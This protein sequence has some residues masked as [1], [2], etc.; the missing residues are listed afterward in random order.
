MA[1]ENKQDDIF[2][3]GDLPDELADRGREVW[4]AGLGAV[5]TVEE[6]GTK[7]F[8]T[9]VRRGEQFEQRGKKQLDAAASEINHQQK[10]A[11]QQVEG[12]VGRVEDIVART[13][14][15]VLDRFDVPTR[16]EINNLAR[17]VE[18]LSEKIDALAGLL[19]QRAA[20]AASPAAAQTTY[21]VVPHEGGWAVMKE[22]AERAAGVHGTKK[23]AVERGR[24]LAH[25]HEPSTLVLFK[26]DGA[27]QERLTYGDDA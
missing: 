24:R 21:H 3:L 27:V 12:T 19:E 22:G 6:E 14:K 13:T 17:R 4:L 20:A 1:T 9:L 11:V 2:R 23:E 10:Q 26:Q 25:D 16:K 7:M 5:A 8:G 18:D 15:T